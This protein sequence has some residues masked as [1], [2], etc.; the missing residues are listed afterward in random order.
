MFHRLPTNVLKSSSLKPRLS[1][2]GQHV[3]LAGCTPTPTPMPVEELPKL[4]FPRSPRPPI[5]KDPIRTAAALV[6]GD[7]VLN[8]K[9]QDTNSHYLARRLFE[10]GI[11][12]KRIE[13]IPDDEVEIVRAAQTLSAKFDLVVTSGGIGPTHDDITYASLAK[14]F[15]KELVMNEEVRRR[16]AAMSIYKKTWLDQQTDEQRAARD[17]MAQFPAGAEVLFVA[18]DLWVP[19]VRLEH[20]VCILPGIPTLYRRML[21]SLVEHYLPLPPERPSRYLVFTTLPESTIAPYLANLQARV[22]LEGIRIGS[23][24]TLYKGVTVSMIG[25]KLSRLQELGEEVCREVQGTVVEP[26]TELK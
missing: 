19:V 25:A 5:P 21:D 14:A 11:E 23:Y 26:P 20:K 1:L 6:I 17:R 2:L 9:T 22:K 24:P 10:M 18:E 4:T 12:L 16:M 8:G 13:V 7:E 15:N 3:R